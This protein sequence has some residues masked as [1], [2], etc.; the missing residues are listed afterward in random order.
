MDVLLLILVAVAVA[1][2]KIVVFVVTDVV[3]FVE[4][5]GMF[6]LHGQG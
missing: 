4:V 1:A 3:I 5:L 6:L 2:T